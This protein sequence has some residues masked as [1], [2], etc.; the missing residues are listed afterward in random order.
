MPPFFATVSLWP[1]AKSLLAYA[2]GQKQPQ[3]PAAIAVDA[4]KPFHH[5]N[6]FIRFR[7]SDLQ[8]SLGGKNPLPVG[9]L[10]V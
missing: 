7:P 9:A 1:D 4:K 10:T 6:A 8:G 5:E 2:Y 3:H